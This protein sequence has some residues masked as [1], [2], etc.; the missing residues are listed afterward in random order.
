MRKELDS[1]N[2]HEVADLIPFSVPAG[3]SVIGT[4]LVYRVKTEGRFKARV[5]VQGWAQQHGIDCSTTFAPVCPISSQLMLLAIAA[6][7][8][9]PVAAMDVQTA[10]LNGTLSEN[11]YIK[12]APGFEK[13]DSST[14]KPYA[15]KLRKSL[16]GLR[17]SPNVWNLTIDRDL[18]RKG[19]TQAASDPCVYTKGSG[20]SYVMLTLFVDDILLTGPSE[21]VLQGVRRDLP[22]SFVMT[23]MGEATQI[24]GIDIKQDLA[25]G[26]ITL[27]QE[28][29]TI[30]VLKRYKMDTANPVH[31]PA[32][33]A[34]L[35]TSDD[36]PLL[37]DTAKRDYQSAVGSLIFL[38]NC[39]RFYIAFATIQVAR[40][41]S[42]PREIPLG[43]LKRIFC[44]LRKEA[45]STP[46]VQEE[47]PFRAHLLLECKLRYNQGLPERH[48]IHGVSIRRAHP[49]RI[50]SPAHHGYL[51][52]RSRD[53]CYEHYR[54]TRA[55]LR[56]LNGRI[57]LEQAAEVQATHRQPERPRLDLHRELQQPVKAHRS[58]VQLSPG[59]GSF[60][61]NLS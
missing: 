49:L 6:F 28:R 11:V 2:D 4:N 14:G 23:D 51:I 18:R 40:H 57:G 41:I 19:F 47:Q 9:W 31:T 26:T 43:Q 56:L 48:W 16:H 32:T 7:H 35:Q 50:L 58:S 12:Q 27:S 1:L 10:F 54:K 53:Y 3:Y 52:R 20:N 22:Q 29:Y 44:Y 21:Q 13:T 24:L 25:N 39:T 37:S 33:P 34:D 36:S 8:G 5:V 17:Q 45:S 38:I 46:A 15:W 30:S 61:S 55:L 60:R 42:S 59:L